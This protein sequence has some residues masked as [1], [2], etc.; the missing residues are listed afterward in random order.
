MDRVLGSRRLPVWSLDQTVFWIAANIDDRDKANS[1]K[2]GYKDVVFG[3]AARDR[4]AP[5]TKLS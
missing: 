2:P 4:A 5:P 1:G 3:G